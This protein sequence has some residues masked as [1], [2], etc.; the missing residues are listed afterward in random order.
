MLDGQ[1]VEEGKADEVLDAPIHPATR[2]L[3]KAAILT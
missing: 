2:A 3:V 1:I